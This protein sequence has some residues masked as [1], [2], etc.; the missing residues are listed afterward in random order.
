MVVAMRLLLL[1]LNHDRQQR[2]VSE[3]QMSMRLPKPMQV[4]TFLLWL[5]WEK[6]AVKAV[7][8]VIVMRYDGV[9]WIDKLKHVELES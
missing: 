9:G 1:L 4:V 7:S 8:I 5:W 3:A 2:F 6:M